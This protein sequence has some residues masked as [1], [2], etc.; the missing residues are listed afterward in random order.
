M[1]VTLI[2]DFEKLFAEFDQE[3]LRKLRRRSE[4]RLRK[5]PSHLEPGSNRD[6][7]A[8]KRLVPAERKRGGFRGLAGEIALPKQ[9]VEHVVGQGS[10]G[11]D[12]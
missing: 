7:L 1:P 12:F 2:N 6:A 10:P 4:D 5:S 8:G 11:L 3:S 9:A